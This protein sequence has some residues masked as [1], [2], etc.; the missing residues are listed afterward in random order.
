M[1]ELIAQDEHGYN[2]AAQSFS[3]IE[4]I[5]EAIELL[6]HALDDAS[7]GEAHAIQAELDQLN[8]LL[9]SF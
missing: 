7:T 3:S 4:Q 9:S 6:D 5:K 2:Y 8:H 1:M